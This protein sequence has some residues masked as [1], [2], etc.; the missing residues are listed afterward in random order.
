MFSKLSRPV[1]VPPTLLSSANPGEGNSFL[2][3]KR[4]AREADHPPSVEV[5][6]GVVRN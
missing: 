5:M 3:I 1:W 2:G 6:N 4:P